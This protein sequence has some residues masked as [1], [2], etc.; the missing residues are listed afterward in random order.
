MSTVEFNLNLLRH[1]L[2]STNFTSGDNVLDAA[3]NLGEPAAVQLVLLGLKVRNNPRTRRSFAAVL[4]AFRK[5]KKPTWY[6]VLKSHLFALYSSLR[7]L[8]IPTSHRPTTCMTLSRQQRR[9]LLGIGLAREDRRTLAQRA[10]QAAGTLFG[11]CLTFIF[12]SFLFDNGLFVYP[13]IH[14]TTA[15]VGHVRNQWRITR[16]LHGSTTGTKF[17]WDAVSLQNRKN[18]LCWKNFNVRAQMRTMTWTLRHTSFFKISFSR[19]QMRSN[20]DLNWEKIGFLFLY[21]TWR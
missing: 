1:L 8:C 18:L 14:F 20:V 11:P 10:S 6:R 16:C 9:A 13:H 7:S 19:A 3:C 4:R 12:S 21:L 2:R 5:A 15:A 17:D